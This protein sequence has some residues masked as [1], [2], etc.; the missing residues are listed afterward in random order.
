MQKNVFSVKY[1]TIYIY[2]VISKHR[3]IVPKFRADGFLEQKKLEVNVL[4]LNL[5]PF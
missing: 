4:T 2:L 3:K 5:T 1:S